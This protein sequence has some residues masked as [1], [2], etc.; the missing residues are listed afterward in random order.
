MS[1]RRGFTLIELLVVIGIVALL[2]AI[3]L[4]LLASSRSAA[5]SMAC[6]VNLRQIGLLTAVYLDDHG[7]VFPVLNNRTS[8][9]EPVP[10]MDTALIEP[11]DDPAVFD[12]P[13]DEMWFEQAGTS[14][15]WNFTVNGQH[16]EQ[17]FSIVGGASPSRV[18]LVSDREAFH[19]DLRD[20]INVLYAD[21]HAK[22]ELQFNAELDP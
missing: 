16:V 18:P 22:D 11:S 17:L 13:A 14:Y 3:A 15:F 10:A 6:A 1:R 9:A 12:C 4:P 7:Q 21:G 2:L 19:P 20:R 8:K 5:R